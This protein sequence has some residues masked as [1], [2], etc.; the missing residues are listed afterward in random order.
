MK[1]SSPF[2]LQIPKKKTEAPGKERQD[3]E[4]REREKEKKRKREK[5]K[6]NGLIMEE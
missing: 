6:R 3:M 2:L 5:E 1:A 4:K